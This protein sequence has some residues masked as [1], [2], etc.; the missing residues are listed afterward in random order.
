MR[1]RSRR[2]SFTANL[3]PRPGGQFSRGRG[4]YNCDFALYLHAAHPS[5]LA[6]EAHAHLI[7]ACDEALRMSRKGTDE[8]R[9]LS[10]AAGLEEAP[11]AVAA[12]KAQL[13]E[14][15]CT[16]SAKAV[17]LGVSPVMLCSSAVCT[18]DLMDINK[19]NGG[20]ESGAQELHPRER[21]AQLFLKVAQRVAHH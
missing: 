17:T 18:Q 12:S 19:R 2:N 9:A 4:L 1:G 11:C 7:D 13:A 20:G 5:D 6:S 10:N 16:L 3:P 21:L 15:G 14:L 8:S